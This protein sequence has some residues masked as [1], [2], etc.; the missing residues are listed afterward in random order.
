[1]DWQRVKVQELSEQVRC[2]QQR[3]PLAATTG[4]P[5]CQSPARTMRFRVCG[6]GVMQF[7]LMKLVYPRRCRQGACR[8]RWT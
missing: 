6:G 7:V 4:G 1:M 5:P 3:L 2:A 8:A